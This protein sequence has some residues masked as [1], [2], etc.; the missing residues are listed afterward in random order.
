MGREL[1]VHRIDFMNNGDI[2]IRECKDDY[3]CGRTDF[4]GDIASL[5]Y[6][7]KTSHIILDY[8]GPTPAKIHV[9]TED[10]GWDEKEFDLEFD[11]AKLSYVFE[12]CDEHIEKENKELAREQAMME[13]ARIARQHT[14]TLQDFQ[15]FSELL[16]ELQDHYDR[17]CK[18]ARLF[19]NYIEKIYKDINSQDTQN[20][21]ERSYILLVLSE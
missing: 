14:R 3:I 5:F 19:K 21:I 9:K 10:D 6:N 16:D 12:I 17:F 4:T 18:E 7:R 1:I 13:D 11:E 2:I 20:E 8:D 15:D